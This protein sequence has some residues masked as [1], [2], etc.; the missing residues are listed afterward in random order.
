MKL[1]TLPRTLTGLAVIGLAGCGGVQSS[2]DPAGVEAREISTLFWTVTIVGLA[3]TFLVTA[4]LLLALYG[5]HRIRSRLAGHA[6][7]LALGIALPV[8]ILS[9]LLIY[10]LVL[11]Q[12]G[13]ARSGRAESEIT[14]TGKQWWWR[15]AYHL[16]DGSTAVSANELRL[17]VGEAVALHLESE[18]VI[19]SF[20]APRLG[21]KL[22]MIPGRT[23]TLTVEASEAGLSRAQCAEYCGGAHALMAM[24]VVTMAKSDY[25]AWLVREAGPAQAPATELEQ[26][27]S[28]VFFAY[29]CGSCHTIR[30]TEATGVAGPDLTHVGSRHS[31]GAATLANTPEAFAAWLVSNQHVKPQN[32]MPEYEVLSD[33]ELRAVAAYLDGL[34]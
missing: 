31:L 6:T 15:V 30:G 28:E 27:G 20:W 29:G 25:E 13:Q 33:E 23:N 24:D 32:L 2:L 5:P 26:R 18:D 3:T 9:G 14:I 19:H 10:G 1:R 22:D 21:G 12:A 7:I 16:P 11:M 8:L 34:E 4:C 17:P